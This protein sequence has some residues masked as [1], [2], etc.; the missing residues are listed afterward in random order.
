VDRDAPDGLA[1]LDGMEF[2]ALVDV[3][4]RPSRV[5]RALRALGGRVGHVGYVSSVSVYTGAGRGRR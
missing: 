3:A 5:R 4:S 2:D 1:P